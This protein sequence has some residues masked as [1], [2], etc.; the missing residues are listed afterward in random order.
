M[1]LRLPSEGC[2]L[3]VAEV[4]GPTVQGEGPSVGRRASFIRLGGCNLSCSWCDTPYTWD[5][6]RYQLRTEL[7]RWPVEDILDRAEQDSPSLVVITGG[8]PMLHQQQPGWDYLLGELADVDVEI[9]TNGTLTPTRTTELH[10]PRYNVSP[11][12]SHT[13]DSERARIKPE[14]LRCFTATGRAVFKF[15]CATPEHVDEAAE[16]VRQLGIPAGTVW[17]SPEG[18]TPRA[19]LRHQAAIAEATIEHGYNLGTRLHTL[20]WGDERAR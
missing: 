7:V 3:V 1:T 19:V 13:G 11:K 8:E 15:V 10:A 17:I 20:V 12:L 4:F 18:T 6:S 5:A 14:I 9:E 16:L 2:T